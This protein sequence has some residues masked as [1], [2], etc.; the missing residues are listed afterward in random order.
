M[1]S[2]YAKPNFAFI[3]I[4][5][6][7]DEDDGPYPVGQRFNQL[8]EQLKTDGKIA[9]DLK[10]NVVYDDNGRHSLSFG[11]SSGATWLCGHYAG[12]ILPFVSFHQAFS[13]RDSELKE[14]FKLAK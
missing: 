6:E 9:N 14:A 3:T 11:F 4:N 8:L 12:E 2:I 7:F 10:F 13:G 5:A 1:S